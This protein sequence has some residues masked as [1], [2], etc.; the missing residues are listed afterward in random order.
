MTDFARPRVVVSKCLGFAACRWNEAVIE[1]E[2]VDKLGEWVESVPVCP[3]VGSGLSVPRDPVR[4]V[5]KG[6]D[7]RLIQ[8]ATG[9][10]WTEPAR[11]F[12]AGFLKNL[13]PVD[14][15]LLKSRSPSCGPKD[16][17]IYSGPEPGA[18]ARKGTGLF[19]ASVK[20]A[21]PGAAMEHEGR[22]KNFRLR[23]HFLT[24]LFA[25]AELRRVEEQGTV[26]GLIEFQARYKLLL[27]GYN[28]AR[29]RT[30]GKI[31]ANPGKE[32]FHRLLAAYRDQLDPAL[33]R[34][35]KA[36]AIIN[37]LMHAAGYFKKQLTAREKAHFLE[38]LDLYRQGRLLLGT[39]QT[40]L[41]SWILRYDQAYLADQAFSNRIRL[42]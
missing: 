6:E 11:E 17:R 21:F 29:M 38:T 41:Y 7:V 30:M 22:V 34:A 2:F 25:L 39:L 14:G 24:K 36:P 4:L 13:G 20:K 8:P 27:M 19:A 15:F 28:Q 33:A 12:V 23:E 16:V 37:V 10:D 5:G 9:I 40:L 32:P 26:A 31:V 3:E 18:A 42:T 35:P 1:D